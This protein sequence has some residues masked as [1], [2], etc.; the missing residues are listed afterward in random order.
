MTKWFKI[1]SMENGQY[2]F[3]MNDNE[4]SIS[5]TLTAKDTQDLVK[6]VFSQIS[7]KDYAKLIKEE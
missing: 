2:H 3:E 4:T 5:T 6:E 1:Y 7:L